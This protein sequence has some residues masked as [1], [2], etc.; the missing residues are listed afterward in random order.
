VAGTWTSREKFPRQQQ[1]EGGRGQHSGPHSYVDGLALT[2]TASHE[3]VKTGNYNSLFVR[4]LQVVPHYVPAVRFGGPQIVAHFLGRQLVRRGH[5]VTVVTTNLMDESANLNVPIDVPVDVEGIQVFYEPVRLWRYSGFS[6]MLARR[7]RREAERSDAMMVHF[8]YQFSSWIG[9]RT[10]R[11][12]DKPYVV[13]SHGSL[14]HANLSH[15]KGWLK[16]R[17]LKTI[18]DRNLRQARFVAFNS[19]DELSQSYYAEFGKVVASGIETSQYDHL[20]PAGQ[21]RRAYGLEEKH[22]LLFIGR[23]DIAHKGIDILLSAFARLATERPEIHLVLAGPDERGDKARIDTLVEDLR[24]RDR[25]TVTGLLTGEHK[26]AALNDAAAFVQPSRMEG[27]SIALLEALYMRL[28]ALVSDQASLAKQVDAIGAGVIV[29]P[30]AQ[31]VYEGLKRLPSKEQI[32][33]VGRRLVIR[34]FSGETSAQ[35]LEESLQQ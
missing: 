32:G 2:E 8:H 15:R 23:L 22:I 17:Y 27:L 5:E 19:P 13:F 16:W 20:P 24:I 7:V 10:A 12:L 3:I 6:P 25:V 34:D 9:G 29:H 4:F 1:R 18:E 21:F 35:L 31:A 28:P 11:K 26:L 33:D 30:D 14:L